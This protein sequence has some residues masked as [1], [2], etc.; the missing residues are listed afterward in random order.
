MWSLILLLVFSL[1]TYTSS[2]HVILIVDDCQDWYEIPSSSYEKEEGKFTISKGDTP[3]FRKV[4]LIHGWID[5]GDKLA[6]LSMTYPEILRVPHVFSS[7]LSSDDWTELSGKMFIVRPEDYCSGKR[8][9]H[10]HNFKVYEAIIH[11]TR[12]E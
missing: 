5:P 1:T 12:D 3:S 9:I 7:D 8:F 4:M 10:N 6:T 11:V 2:E